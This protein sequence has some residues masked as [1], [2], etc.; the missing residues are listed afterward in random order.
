MSTTTPSS[1]HILTGPTRFLISFTDLFVKDIDEAKFADR[2]GTTVNHPAFVLGHCAYVAGLCMQLLGGELEFGAHEAELYAMGV[3]CSDDAT[4][5]PSKSDSIAAFNDRI[6]TLLDFLETCDD[7]T[8]AKSSEGVWFENYFPTCGGGAAFMLIGH[9][10]FH[11]GQVS[12]W[13]RL[14]GMNH[15]M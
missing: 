5:Y 15:A 7:A 1:T 9:V 2:L 11:L 8:L 14:A 13:R 10:C 3:E 4:R 6:N 12:A